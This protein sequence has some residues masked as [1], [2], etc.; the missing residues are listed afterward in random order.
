MKT[1][2]TLSPELLSADKALRCAATKVKQEV[3]RSGAPYLVAA[4][5]GKEADKPVLNRNGT[6]QDVPLK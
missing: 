6:L 1:T 5:K 2:K 4:E 3:E